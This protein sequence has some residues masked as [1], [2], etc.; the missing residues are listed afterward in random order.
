M[1]EA[2]TSICVLLELDDDRSVYISRLVI[3]TSKMGYIKLPLNAGRFNKNMARTS[4]ENRPTIAI[5][6]LALQALFS[7][8][9][10]VFSERTKR[11]RKIGVR[12]TVNNAS[13]L[14]KLMSHITVRYL[15]RSVFSCV[16]VDLV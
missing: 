4:S 7:Y 15:A 9:L 14:V 11:S 1:A 6:G 16:L 10:L 5:F 3:S 12:S 2:K 8:V 13:A